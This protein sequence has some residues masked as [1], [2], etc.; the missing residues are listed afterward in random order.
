MESSDNDNNNEN[1]NTD[2]NLKILILGD[3]NVGKTSLLLQYVDGY[4]PTIYC[5]TIGIEYK[6]KK[7]NINGT[8]IN[9][10]IWDTAGEER[11]RSITQNFMKGAD[12]IL[13]VYDIT[14]KS[15]FDN[16]KTWMSQSEEST[17]GFK[18][19]IIGNKSDLENKR[20]VTK[21]A[22]KKFCE[23]RNVKGMEVSAKVGTKITDAF[24]LLTKSIIG[25]KSKDEIIRKYTKIEKKRGL[26]I[27]KQK[28]KKKTKKKFC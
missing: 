7:I 22:L 6:I 16:L 27:E 15:S 23:E 12:G 8:D 13:Y 25:D 11:F 24:E 5:A 4:F 14:Q 28:K 19:I 26:T 3:S 2:V 21:E 20:K 18:K 17:E 10:Q 9:L 1:N